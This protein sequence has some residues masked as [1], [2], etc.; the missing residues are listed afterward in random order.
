MRKFK[1]G[2]EIVRVN[3]GERY[4]PLGFTTIVNTLYH[5]TDTEGETLVVLD[6][7]WALAFAPNWTPENNE[8]P[9]GELTDVQQGA[10]L[11]C[12]HRRSKLV[13]RGLGKNWDTVGTPSW[14]SGMVYRK[15]TPVTLVTIGGKKYREDELTLALANIKEVK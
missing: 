13:F 8:L 15:V 4:A 1:V 11:L 5:Y 14:R 9:W 3:N 6:N 10:F 2:D 12:K 7:L